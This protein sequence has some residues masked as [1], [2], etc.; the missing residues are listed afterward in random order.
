MYSKEELEEA[1]ANLKIEAD[2][3]CSRE[4]LRQRGA[5]ENCN[6][7]TRITT[8]DIAIET[9]T[10]QIPLLPIELWQ[11]EKHIRDVCQNCESIYGI[12]PRYEYCPDCGQKIDWSDK[13]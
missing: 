2:E 1:I 5:W 12:I 9:L 13:V 7:C 4:C 8:F 6:F 3:I 10:K 11:G